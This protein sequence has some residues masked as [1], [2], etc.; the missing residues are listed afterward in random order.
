MRAW[1]EKSW[2]GLD[3]WSESRSRVNRIVCESLRPLRA[4][5]GGLGRG[6][7]LLRG[8]RKVKA[9]ESFKQEFNRAYHIEHPSL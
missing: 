3:K 4:F 9:V 7:G 8:N 1:R 6:S 5:F 2:N